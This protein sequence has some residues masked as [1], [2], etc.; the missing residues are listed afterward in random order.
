M[1][2]V[3]ESKKKIGHNSEKPLTTKDVISEVKMIDSI[4]PVTGN[5]KKGNRN[6]IKRQTETCVQM[7]RKQREYSLERKTSCPKNKRKRP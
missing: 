3:T 4:E 2:H 5:S 6:P 1:E 7:T